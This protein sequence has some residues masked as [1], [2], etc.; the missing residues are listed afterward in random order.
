M[1]AFLAPLGMR[2]TV[3]SLTPSRMRIIT[4]RRSKSKSLATDWKWAGVSLGRVELSFC[5]A[6]DCD[7][8]DTVKSIPQVAVARNL[9]MALLCVALRIIQLS[10]RRSGD[11]VLW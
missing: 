9:A 6:T 5:C 1:G 11:T 4:S 10:P 7:G 8:E 2:M 3:W